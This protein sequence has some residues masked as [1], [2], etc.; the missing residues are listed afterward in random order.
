MFYVIPDC[1]AIR[2]HFTWSTTLPRQSR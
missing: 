1:Q 2:T